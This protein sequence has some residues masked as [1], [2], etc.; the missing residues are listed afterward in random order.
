MAENRRRAGYLRETVL[1]ALHAARRPLSA[2]ELRQIFH[3]QGDPIG[4]NLIFRGIRQLVERGAIR[5][6]LV[7]RGYAPG[8]GECRVTLFCRQCGQVTEITCA[9][10][11]D[12]LDEVAMAGGFAVSRHIVEVSGVCGSCVAETSGDGQDV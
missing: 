4:P 12:A 6:V 1:Q 11:F 10:A 8:S 3:R 5:K 7:A 9:D 2:L